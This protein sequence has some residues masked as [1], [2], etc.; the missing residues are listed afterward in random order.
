MRRYQMQKARDCGFQPPEPTCTG[1]TILGFD[2]GG[3]WQFQI[4]PSCNPILNTVSK[5]TIRGDGRAKENMFISRGGFL[6]E[7]E[8]IL[9][10]DGRESNP[11]TSDI[12][13]IDPCEVLRTRLPLEHTWSGSTFLP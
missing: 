4:L 1:C 10:K 7:I 5:R 11:V 13:Y 9:F 3:G 12:I 2:G 6:R 8:D